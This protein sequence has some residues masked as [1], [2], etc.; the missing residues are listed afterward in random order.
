M[1]DRYPDIERVLYMRQRKGLVLVVFII[2]SLGLSLQSAAQEEYVIGEGDL[3]RITVYD[4]PDLTTEVRVSGGKITFPLIGEVMIDEL[5]VSEVE[6]KIAAQLANGF[7][8]Q[9]HVSVL[10][11]DFKKTVF[12]NGEVRNPG[13]YKFTKGLTVLKAITLAGG[14]TAKASEGRTRIIRNTDKGEVK[15]KAR[16]DDLLEPDDIILVPESWF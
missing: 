6:K 1:I 16:M 3:I 7:I 11:L 2:L 10:I 13:A 8:I 5:T 12:V 14:F 9:P 4:N 15:I